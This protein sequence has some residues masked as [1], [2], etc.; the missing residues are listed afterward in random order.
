M[1]AATMR[2]SAQHRPEVS[3]GR[4]R[5]PAAKT[6][7]RSSG[8]TDRSRGRRW[9]D[10]ER[11]GCPAGSPSPAGSVPVKTTPSQAMVSRRPSRSISTPSTRVEAVDGDELGARQ[12]GHAEQTWR[13]IQSPGRRAM[14]RSPSSI[15]AAT[16]CRHGARSAGAENE[17]SSV[18]TTTARAN[19]L[20]MLE[21]DH[22]LEGAGGRDAPGP[23]CP[24]R[25]ARCAASP[26]MPVASSTQRPLSDCAA[27][28]R[29][30]RR[31]MRP[32]GSIGGHGGARAD[33]D[34]ARRLDQAPRIGRARS[35]AGRELADAE[36]AVAAMAGD[37]AGLA[38][39]L[40]HDD[41][42]HAEAS[43]PR[44]PPTGRR[45]RRRR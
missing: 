17:T 28:C 16:G 39:A 34:A 42:A 45:A 9:R 12:H 31:A 19:G 21:I 24:R 36:P 8:S 3:T 35:S 5:L 33:L 18:P 41:V 15:M 29:D 2:P 22:L 37:A 11:G 23:R 13:A 26:A 32:P 14:M 4:S 10:R 30:A 20:A 38:L 1:F 25:G 43:E 44:A 7:G 27:R 40:Q 6:C